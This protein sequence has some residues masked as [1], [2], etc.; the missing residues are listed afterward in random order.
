M[1]KVL[2]AV[3]ALL[4]LAGCDKPEPPVD[5]CHAPDLT[6][7]ASAGTFAGEKEAATLC[8]KKAAFEMTK[9]GQPVAG[10][11]AAAMARCATLEAAIGKSEP[12]EDWQRKALHETLTHVAERTA[13]QS[14]S[15]GCGRRPG[16]AKDTI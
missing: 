2:G 11:G 10:I 15:M 4:I 7:K 6:P 3:A 14:R 16:E 13:T 9:A 1:L 5:P 12:L 8:I